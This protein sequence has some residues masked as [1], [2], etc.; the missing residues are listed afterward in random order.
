MIRKAHIEDT[1]RIL[2][3][4]RSAQLSLR[5]LGID[6]WQDGY[7]SREVIDADI[8]A[9]VGWVITDVNDNIIGYSAIVMSGEPAY[10]QIADSSWHTPNDYVVVHR[11]CVD[12]TLHRQGTATALMRHAANIARNEG[13][14]GFRIDTH[15]GNIRML[16][17]VERLGFSYCGIITY[18]SGERLA[19][20]LDL[21]LSNIL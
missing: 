12:S 9:G 5:E 11:L 18:D 3:I 8:T 15:R 21:D 19:F 14:K 4:V 1:E 16:A 2:S 17:L 10:T 13:I 20:D 7:P 6:Q